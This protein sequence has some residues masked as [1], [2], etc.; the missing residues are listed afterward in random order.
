MSIET[1]LGIVGAVL[2]I[3]GLTA[4]LKVKNE[5]IKLVNFGVVVVGMILIAIAIVGLPA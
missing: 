2:V 1:I 5:R 3:A 4:Y